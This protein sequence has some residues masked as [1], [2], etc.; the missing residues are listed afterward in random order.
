[1]KRYT[2]TFP[3]AFFEI[4]IKW[5]KPV[6]LAENWNHIS[7]LDQTDMYL[8]RIVAKRGDKHKLLYIGMTENQSIHQRLYNGD[9]QLKQAYMKE[10]NSGWVLYVSLGE[11]ILKD[12]DQ[13][14]LR[15][16]RK[17]TKIIEKLLI[18][19]HSEF[20]SLVNKKSINWFST[21][22]WVTLRNQG[23]LADG[24]R[25]TISYGLFHR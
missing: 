11:Y 3:E 1:M 2:E 22:A 15:W 25:K 24:F 6:K 5:T 19:S 17:H 18:I 10:Q 4:F 23:F 16:A 20:K 7:Q 21:G 9:H 13:K 12:E 14:S 8:Y